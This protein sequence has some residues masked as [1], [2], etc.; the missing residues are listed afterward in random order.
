MS[1]SPAPP[2]PTPAPAGTGISCYLRV[3]KRGRIFT[4]YL[5]SATQDRIFG[6]PAAGMKFGVAIGRGSD[7]GK[8]QL[9]RLPDKTE[10]G[11][12]VFEAGSSLRGGATIKCGAW[13]LLPKDKRPG[14]TVDL[15]HYDVKTI[16]L[17]LPSWARPSGTG[18]VMAAEHG[19]KPVPRAAV[20]APAEAPK[21][22]ANRMSEQAAA[23]G[24]AAK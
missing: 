9:M 15:I 23:I 18:G 12:H 22:G 11:D 21:G 5:S 7:E 20:G 10:P 17:R 1:F 3:T 6:G 24:R 2:I 13:D 16:T 4:L 14:S 19:L 8:L